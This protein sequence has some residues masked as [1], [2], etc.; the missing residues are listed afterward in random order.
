[1]TFAVIIAMQSLGL[2]A[3][4]GVFVIR[5][6]S[7]QRCA[8]RY[9]AQYPPGLRTRCTQRFIESS[10]YVRYVRAMGVICVVVGI[11][12]VLLTMYYLGR[13]A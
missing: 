13:V 5:P 3:V 2:I 10:G 4:G 7:V 12:E 6:D 9:Y 11:G 1:M 8:I